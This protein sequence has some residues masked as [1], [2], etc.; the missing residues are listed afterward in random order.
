MDSGP[1]DAEGLFERGGKLIDCNGNFAGLLRESVHHSL[2]DCRFMTHKLGSGDDQG[3]VVV[4]IMPHIA[5]LAIQLAK[6]FDGQG[7]WLTG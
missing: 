3:Q 6:L 1:S 4:D 7:Y 5:E 2:G